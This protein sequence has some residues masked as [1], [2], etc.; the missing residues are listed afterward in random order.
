MAPRVHTLSRIVLL[1]L[2]VAV[3]GTAGAAAPLGHD[4]LAP[5][6][7]GPQCNGWTQALPPLPAACGGAAPTVAQC[8]DPNWLKTPCGSDVKA[9]QQGYCQKAYVDDFCKDKSTE[10]LV[11]PVANPKSSALKPINNGATSLFIPPGQTM[12]GRQIPYTPSNHP[13][14]K[15]PPNLGAGPPPVSQGGGAM[16]VRVIN[17]GMGTFTSTNMGQWV[18]KYTATRQNVSDLHFGLMRNVAPGTLA[19]S[20]EALFATLGPDI[21][22]GDGTDTPA[23]R[24]VNSCGEFVYQRW[25]DYTHYKNMAKALGR[26]YRGIYALAMDPKS[27]VNLEKQV[28][29]QFAIGTL[30]ETWPTK[31][32][33]HDPT[34]DVPRNIFFTQPSFN[35]KVDGAKKQAILA[36]IAKWNDYKVPNHDSY[37]TL[38]SPKALPRFE[39][40]RRLRNQIEQRYHLSDDGFDE[41]AARQSRYRELL[42]SRD[43]MMHDLMCAMAPKACCEPAPIATPGKL[44]ALL[45]KIRGAAVINPDPTQFGQNGVDVGDVSPY[46]SFNS[47][48]QLRLGTAAFGA[49]GIKSLDAAGI[50]G[51]KQ[52]GTPFGNKPPLTFSRGPSAITTSTGQTCE[53]AW[54]AK[55][56][57]LQAAM[58]AIV[59]QLTD[60]VVKEFDIPD[61]CLEDPGN[62]LGN[63]CDWSYEKFAHLTMSYFDDEVEEDFQRCNDLTRGAF[64]NVRDQNRQEPFIYPCE[65]RH[66]FGA[67]QLDVQYFLDAT[68]ERE[69]RRACDVTRAQQ[70]VDAYLKQYANIVKRIPIRGDHIGESSGD[71]WTLG[72]TGSF[73][74]YMKYALG[75]EV[76]GGNGNP[77]T[78]DGAWCRLVGNGNMSAAAGFYFFGSDAKVLD[79]ASNSQTTE[80]AVYYGA[81]FRLMDLETLKVSDLFPPVPDHTKIPNP[82]IVIPVGEPHILGDIRYDFWVQIGPIPLHVFFGANASVGLSVNELGHVNNPTAC[83]TAGGK[84]IEDVKLDFAAGTNFEPW[85]RADAY[86]DA[87]IDVVVASA[88]IRLDLLLLKI[89][90]P[91]GAWSQADDGKALVVRSGSILTVDALEGRVSAYVRLGIYPLAYTIEVTLFGWD[92]LHAE[93]PL[94]GRD[95][96]WPVKLATWAAQSKIDPKSVKCSNYQSPNYKGQPNA[97]LDG[98]NWCLKNP[99]LADDK[100]ALS[101]AIPFAPP[102]N[103]P[104]CADKYALRGP[105]Q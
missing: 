25:Y 42:I 30:P 46:S 27:P 92:G 72:D 64:V 102:A 24:Q 19:K 3:A 17:N 60:L 89:G 1:M 37:I 61:G 59:D 43:G 90:L 65:V 57:S 71:T 6:K 39:V 62:D 48:A 53:Q 5:V 14:P 18:A 82:P 10:E 73:G 74:A 29:K 41:R 83:A 35:Q 55:L 8:S 31:Y 103:T 76:S 85:V 91:T 67:D 86:A 95:D 50:A 97:L 36:R 34:T 93:T 58:N 13:N 77:K 47:A 44:N 69:I 32:S 33:Y 80:D 78:S 28:L 88:G 99:T 98:H 21:W 51:G 11:Y 9:V 68:Q 16:P 104:W 20:S 79:A 105:L 54:S 52:K 87:S 96:S 56:P 100:K 84:P 49:K 26:D 45:D 40:H 75:W 12:G 22:V 94:F 23:N 101:C 81:H 2:G 63:S 38:Q 4:Q 7:P 66:D 15:P 70:A